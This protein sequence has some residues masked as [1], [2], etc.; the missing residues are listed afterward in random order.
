MVVLAERDIID[1]VRMRLHLLAE[2]GGRRLIIGRRFG[3][4][5]EVESE[6]PGADDAVSAAGVSVP[7]ST[8]LAMQI[9]ENLVVVG[10]R[11]V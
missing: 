2:S 3:G 11:T 9:G 8:L 1:P 7:L 6:V 10:I 4:V 5:V